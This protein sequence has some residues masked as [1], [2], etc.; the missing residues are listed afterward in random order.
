MEDHALM[1]A[2]QVW[3]PA[4]HERFAIHHPG[5]TA[6]ES[7]ELG[8]HP[9]TLWPVRGIQDTTRSNFASTLSGERC[10]LGVD[11]FD[12]PLPTGADH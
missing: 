2:A 12:A 4:D 8:E 10:D 6:G 11:R 5:R 3:H 9:Q 7:I 1:A